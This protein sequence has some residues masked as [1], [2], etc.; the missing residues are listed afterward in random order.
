M[1]RDRITEIR[2]FQTAETGSTSGRIE[3]LFTAWK[4]I[5]K[6]GNTTGLSKKMNKNSSKRISSITSPLRD[7]KINKHNITNTFTKRA[8]NASINILDTTEL[9]SDS[10][11][12]LL[13]EDKVAQS[14][15]SNETT[16][17]NKVEIF[18]TLNN[19]R[20]WDTIERV[21][22][23][24]DKKSNYVGFRE[25]VPSSKRF[26]RHPGLS[27]EEQ[28]NQLD[29]TVQTR[30]INQNLGSAMNKLDTFESSQPETTT[31]YP[32]KEPSK[33]SYVPIFPSCDDTENFE[34]NDSDSSTRKNLRNRSNDK[35]DSAETQEAKG[36]KTDRNVLNE[37][38]QDMNKLQSSVRQQKKDNSYIDIRD[39]Q[40]SV[41]N[42]TSSAIVEYNPNKIPYVEVPDYSDIREESLDE[43][44]RKENE[45]RTDFVDPEVSTDLK[46]S[47]KSPN[48]SSEGSVKD[49]SRKNSRQNLSKESESDLTN[50]D[51]FS[52]TDK[53]DKDKTKESNSNFTNSDKPSNTDKQD[54]NNGNKS[55]EDLG[56]RQNSDIKDNTKPKISIGSKESSELSKNDELE[57]NDK[58]NLFKDL[59]DDL[60]NAN[61][62]KLEWKENAREGNGEPQEDSEETGQGDSESKSG[63]I[64]FDINEYRKPF[65][66]DEFLKDDPIMKK[67]NLLEKETRTKYGQNGKRVSTDF[68]ESESDNTFRERANGRGNSK[69][70]RDTFDDL[71]RSYKSSDSIFK[72]SKEDFS[73]KFEKGQ[74]D[75]E[76]E[77]KEEAKNDN[78][79]GEDS[80][81]ENSNEDSLIIFKQNR[82]YPLT[83]F[84]NEKVFSSG[85]LK[86][87][88][89]NRNVVDR[90]RKNNKYQEDTHDALSTILSKKSQ[91]SRLDEDIDG[92][93]E[94]GDAY[95]NFW[96]LEY[97]SPRSR[98]DMEA[99]ERRK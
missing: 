15:K 69:E 63:P 97:K 48:D 76:S 93:I 18:E 95:K 36:S 67:L 19:H 71:P 32:S 2:N 62:K 84:E 86:N 54:T 68:N 37:T 16:S 25:Q 4:P 28:Q 92:R 59:K 79:K 33:H 22:R 5:T 41:G 39:H 9:K 11:A 82:I 34:S 27:Y 17:K 98:V 75:N 24:L 45:M 47:A 1:S 66:L 64:I 14:I 56:F 90:R 6:I 30:N 77:A 74:Q 40:K 10:N 55:L 85:Y 61:L 38:F 65:D 46:E 73:S 60:N 44:D 3:S 94:D 58:K 78:V 42:V 57:Q 99:Q 20:E 52:D 89:N 83:K 91:V 31:E 72:K 88:K 13:V 29:H 23:S 7:H 70:V 8:N 80:V 21:K 96:S 12:N 50:L 49:K 43:G 87:K 51:K 53:P 35:V 81:E 26:Y